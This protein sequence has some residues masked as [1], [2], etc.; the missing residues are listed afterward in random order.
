MTQ[1]ALDFV[2]PLQFVGTRRRQAPRQMGEYRL[3]VAVLED[4]VECFQKYAQARSTA[5]RR[6]FAEAERWIMGGTPQDDNRLDAQ[7]L[8]FSF[9]YVCET[10]G[11]EPDYLQG[12]LKRWRDGQQ[13]SVHVVV[14]QQRE[15]E[16]DR[17]GGTTC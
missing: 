11:I 6:L 8:C 9:Y 13:A 3:L 14:Q 15:N 17:E 16:P 2:L 4:A 1:I 7:G 10:L 12:G 5:E